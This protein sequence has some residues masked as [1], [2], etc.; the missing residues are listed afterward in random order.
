MLTKTPKHEATAEFVS[1][2]RPDVL[3]RLKHTT[4]QQLLG[5]VG[6]IASTEPKELRAVTD[7]I[8]DALIDLG[9]KQPSEY[10]AL[11]VT[12]SLL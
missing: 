8:Y 7:A 11:D 3:L 10:S 5:L 12:L 9:L 6:N 2:D 1:E 4:A